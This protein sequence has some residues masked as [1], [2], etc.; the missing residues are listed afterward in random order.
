MLNR[1][2]DLFEADIE[3]F[4]R[5]ETLNNGR[6]VGEEVEHQVPPGK[7]LRVHTGDRVKEGDRLVFGPLVPHEILKVSGIEAVQNY[8]NILYSQFPLL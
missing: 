5:L 2:A 3:E 8:L 6:P 1:F 4:F 7:H